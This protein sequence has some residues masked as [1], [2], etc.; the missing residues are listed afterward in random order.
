MKQ[1]YSNDGKYAW[2]GHTFLF[3]FSAQTKERKGKGP[4]D[5]QIQG[6]E[7]ERGVKGSSYVGLWGPRFDEVHGKTVWKAEGK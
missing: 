5:R 4:A 7:T 6:C 1:S 3:P 2:E